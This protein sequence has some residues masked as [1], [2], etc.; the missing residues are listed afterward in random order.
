M[1]V[2][3]LDPTI[4]RYVID[5]GDSEYIDRVEFGDD[6]YNGCIT[7]TFVSHDSGVLYY[8]NVTDHTE[9]WQGDQRGIKQQGEELISEEI[10]TWRRSGIDPNL[11]YDSAHDPLFEIPDYDPIPSAEAN[12][13]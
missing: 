8:T 12:D 11:E 10:E 3:E 13:D 7:A 9:A 4:A 1:V 6:D 2:K 5:Q